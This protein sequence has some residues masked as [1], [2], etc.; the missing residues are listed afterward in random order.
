MELSAQTVTLVPPF[1]P[2]TK[3]Y[4]EG[5]SCYSFKHGA[6]K[7]TVLKKTKENDWDLGYGFLAI[8]DQDWFSLHVSSENRSV[9]EDLG[10]IDWDGLITVPVLMPLPQLPKRKQREITV[11]SSADTHEKWAKTNKTFSK[12]TLG[13]VYAVHIKN[14]TADFYVLFRVIVF[15]QRKHCTITWRRV[16]PPPDSEPSQ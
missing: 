6:L 12:V 10:Q 11:D 5:H 8:N 7:A 4:N 1:Y 15:D 3:K 16:P 14:D 13:H 9:M 2:I